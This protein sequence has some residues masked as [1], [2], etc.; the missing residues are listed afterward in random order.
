MKSLTQL[1]LNDEDMAFAARIAARLGHK[2]NHSYSSTSDMIGLHCHE[3]RNG[4]K[5]CAIVKTKEF[6]FLIIQDLE[7]LGFNDLH[8]EELEQ[9]RKEDEKAS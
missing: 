9:W 5:G 4:P 6:G 7:G 1:P 8:K 3:K 2:G